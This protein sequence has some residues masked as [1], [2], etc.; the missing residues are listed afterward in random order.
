MVK[1][2]RVAIIAGGFSSEREI[3]LLTGKNVAE[4]LNSKKYSAKIYDL[5][6]DFTRFFSDA[7]KKKFDLVFIALHGKYGEDGTVQGLLELL[8]IPYIGSNVLASALGMNK[9]MSKKN[10]IEAG[11]IT[12]EYIAFSKDEYLLDKK[13]FLKKIRIKLKFPCVVKPCDGGSS[14]AVSIVKS[15]NDLERGINEAFSESNEVIVEKYL[16]GKEIS[17][18]ILGNK[19]LQALPV[20][21]I[22]PRNQFFDYEAKYDSNACKEIIPAKISKSMTNKAQEIAKK[23]HLSLNCRGFSRTDM[24][25]N[26]NKIYVLEVNTIPGMTKN[27][28]LPKSAQAAG[29]S[30]PKLLDKVIQLALNKN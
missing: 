12:P 19:I 2:L 7:Q 9:I 11:I 15:I 26:K 28:L 20:I 5:K 27:S 16:G 8:K 25:L 22:R 10:F 17:V 23:V 13:R 24:I 3:S 21:E 1:K 18:P 4:N 29:I 6:N 14:I 30:F